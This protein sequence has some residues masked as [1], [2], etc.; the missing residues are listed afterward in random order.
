MVET[1]RPS[2]PFFFP[3]P[4]ALSWSNLFPGTSDNLGK[5]GN[6]DS[7]QQVAVA[8]CHVFFYR[9]DGG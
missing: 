4:L 1:A 8:T 2:P 5:W 3:L 7:T 6:G 9:G